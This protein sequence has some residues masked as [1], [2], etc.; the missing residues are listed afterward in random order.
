MATVPP[1][2]GHL[3]RGLLTEIRRSIFVKRVLKRC[4]EAFL[5]YYGERFCSDFCFEIAF[6]CLCPPKAVFRRSMRGLTR[7]WCGGI[8]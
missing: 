7:T 4:L 8:A 6:F 3:I 2:Q 5:V 1:P